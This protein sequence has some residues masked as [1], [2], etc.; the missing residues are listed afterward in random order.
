MP[1]KKPP[2]PSDRVVLEELRLQRAS[3]DR[4][5]ETLDQKSATV[6]GANGIITIVSVAAAVLQF[7]KGSSMKPNYE[8]LL[9]FPVILLLL[10]FIFSV[11]IIWPRTWFWNPKPKVLYEDYL[12]RK[13]ETLK[14]E[15]PGTVAQMVAD[16]WSGYEKNE[17]TLKAKSKWLK[18][19]LAFEVTG[20]S[21]FV[22]YWL[23]YILIGG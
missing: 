3:Q 21:L 20:L 11:F 13:P 17:K 23:V 15:E 18:V 6:L 8:L 7:I 14:Q 12:K 16:L 4:V 10:A 5:F 19:S 2:Y 9:L 1:K 22:A